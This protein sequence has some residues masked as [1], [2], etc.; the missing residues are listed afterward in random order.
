VSGYLWRNGEAS[1]I[2][3]I[4]K[5]HHPGVLKKTQGRRHEI[6]ILN[7]DFQISIKY[8]IDK[9]LFVAESEN[10]HFSLKLLSEGEENR[11]RL[12]IVPKQKMELVAFDVRYKYTYE[13]ASVVFAN[14]YQSWTMSREYGKHDRQHG[15]RGLSKG[16]PA[17]IFAQT[18]GDYFFKSY[19]KTA[20]VFHGYSYS[21]VR[22]GDYVNLF[23]SLLERTGWTIFNFDLNYGRLKIEKDTEGL[24]IDGEYALFDVISYSGAYDEVFDAYFADANV[25]K[26]RVPHLAGYTSWYNYKQKINEDIIL[27][28][29]K[30]LATVGGAA[31]IFQ[32]D[33]GWETMVGDWAID[34]EKFPQ[35]LKSVVDKIHDEKYLAGLWLAPFSAQFKADVAAK[36][37]EWIVRD[38][39]GRKLVAG[40]AWMG[41]Y[42]LDFY[43]PECAEHIKQRF[44]EVFSWGFDMVKLDFL[45]SVCMQPRYGKTRGQIM[46]EAM[47]FLRE[48]CGDKLILGCGV[49]LA[50]AFGKVDF[51]RV[52]CD[53][54]LSF[55]DKF[56]V[57]TTNQEVISTRNAINNNIF[58][59][60]LDGRAFTNDPDVFFLR[61]EN[62][63]YTREQKE[64]LA[65]INSLFG[66]LLFVSDDIGTYDE[67]Q[68]K[69][70]L[71]TYKK[72]EAK[73]LLAEY[74]DANLIKTV[75]SKNGKNYR[76][77]LNVETGECS[78][79]EL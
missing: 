42:A 49:P 68:R 59:R 8:K 26:P 5:G 38:A 56:Y 1:F 79:K 55:K 3:T 15:L 47:D 2:K 17:R 25:N 53:A 71:K 30:G 7:R 35:G 69:I 14:G 62:A 13:E 36:H 63:K 32:I 43:I 41:F 52:S 65:K 67:Y 27:R 23:G 75:Y 50:P 74:V 9:R 44:K 33:D 16:G 28:D 39:K 58:R 72:S 66:N 46:C 40:F 64:L 10:Q 61:N 19:P 4:E 70:L 11:L 37:P 21:Y 24:T 77:I 78:Q 45:Y 12:N 6:M 20:G 48:C 60:H 76:L 22:T 57:K 51:C 54:E 29:L 34:A 31:D 18:S 73:V